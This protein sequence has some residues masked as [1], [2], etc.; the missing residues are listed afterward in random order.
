MTI[1]VFCLEQESIK[2]NNILNWNQSF[3]KIE[4]K[5]KELRI[6][7]ILIYWQKKNNRFSEQ[8]VNSSLNKSE[9]I[10]D[11]VLIS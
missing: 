9:Y 8:V 10:K 5:L 11:T 1:D 4:L 7:I 3:Y 6:I 2:N